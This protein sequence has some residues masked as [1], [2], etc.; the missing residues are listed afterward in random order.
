MKLGVGALTVLAALGTQ[1][2]GNHARQDRSGWPI[3]ESYVTLPA[4][5]SARYVYLGYNELA[6]D[7]TWSRMLVYYGAG[8][9]GENDFRYLSKFIFNVVSLDPTFK[10][11]Y[12]WAAYSITITADHQVSTAEDDI[13]ASIEILKLGM[14]QFPDEYEFFWLAGIRYFLDLK[15]DDPET[16]RQYQEAGADLIEQAMHKPN[17]PKT[18]ALTAA[19]LRSKLGQQEQALANLKQMVLTTDDPAARD[20]MLSA[21]QG[22]G[23]KKLMTE[24]R[25]AAQQF[26][27]L[28]SRDTP[29]V[30]PDMFVI[31]EGPGQNRA[32]SFRS[33]ASQNLFGGEDAEDGLK[34][35]LD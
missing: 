15:S 3:E 14:L 9:L 25:S 33:L 1:V 22:I 30:P 35:F 4:P 6:A 11:A 13:K 26:D 16:Q 28:R 32:I 27:E 17:A 18:L 29:S 12:E 31:L 2:L 8:F 23:S 21:F 5:E 20:K 34:L 19:G 10:K 7:V 24:L